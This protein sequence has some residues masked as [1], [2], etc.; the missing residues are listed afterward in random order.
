MLKETPEHAKA[1]YKKAIIL[2]EENKEEYALEELHK[3]VKIE[4]NNIAIRELIKKIKESL[5]KGD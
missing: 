1:L 5:R 3:A 4:P 2:C